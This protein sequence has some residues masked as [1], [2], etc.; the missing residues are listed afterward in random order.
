MHRRL[1][2]VTLAVHVYRGFMTLCMLVYSLTWI[3]TIIIIV[4]M[5]SYKVWYCLAVYWLVPELKKRKTFSWPVVSMHSIQGWLS[6]SLFPVSVFAGSGSPPTDMEG[7]DLTHV[8][9]C[10]PFSTYARLCY[11]LITLGVYS[12]IRIFANIIV[13]L[14]SNKCGIFWLFTVFCSLYLCWKKRRKI[15]VN[16]S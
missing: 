8:H 10:K 7:S 4:K 13:K 9:I 16:S 14:F 5:Y 3:F 11:V 6:S 2:T 12:L 15:F 1:T